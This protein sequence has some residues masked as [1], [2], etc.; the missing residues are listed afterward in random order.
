MRR[1]AAF[2]FD[3][4]LVRCDSLLRFIPFVVGPARFYWG[5]ALHAPMLMLM[6]MRVI[7]NRDAK[8]RILRHFFRGMPHSEFVR[9]GE[10]FAQELSRYE[11]PPVMQAL[12]RHQEQGDEVLIVSASI[13]EWI[14]PWAARHGIDTLLCTEMEVDAQGKLTGRFSTPNCRCEEKVERL[15]T[16]Y[17]DRQ[18]IYLAAYGDSQG[19][20][21][22]LAYADEAHWVGHARGSSEARA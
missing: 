8:E 19:D 11:N 21:A 15:R 18:S 20:S 12:R 2:D 22:M 7:P 10:A 17:P 1:I 13:R 4:T 14:A 6:L 3:G 5:F 16:A 9:W